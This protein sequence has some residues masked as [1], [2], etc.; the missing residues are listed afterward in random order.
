[1]ERDP[2]IIF[3]PCN[4]RDRP[5]KETCLTEKGIGRGNV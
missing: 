2:S 1:M 3:F 5:S 4:D